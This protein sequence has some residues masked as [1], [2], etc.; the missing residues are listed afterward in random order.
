MNLSSFRR[1]PDTSNCCPQGK[2]DRIGGKDGR[3]AIRWWAAHVDPRRVASFTAS[4]S[5][6]QRGLPRHVPGAPPRRTRPPSRCAV[7]TPARHLASK[8]AVRRTGNALPR[9][10]D[11]YDM[12][13]ACTA[14]RGARAP[15][16]FPVSIDV[17]A[18]RRCAHR[19]GE[20]RLR[21]RHRVNRKARAMRRKPKREQRDRQAQAVTRV[22]IVGKC[23]RNA[24]VFGGTRGNTRFTVSHIEMRNACR[25]EAGR[26]SAHARHCCG[27]SRTAQHI[28][29]TLQKCDLAPGARDADT[30]SC[31]TRQGEYRCVRMHLVSVTHGSDT[32]ADRQVVDGLKKR[33]RR[34]MSAPGTTDTQARSPERAFQHSATTHTRRKHSTAAPSRNPPGPTPGTPPPAQRRAPSPNA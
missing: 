13:G 15:I 30:Q 5:I 19:S 29:E 8:L 6:T 34:A 14:T 20:I 21:Q 11:R 17:V 25:N 1:S 16:R 26:P 9:A 24:S 27:Q 33:E 32:R 22:A 3:M 4:R 23:F 28:E 7:R 12:R 10:H 18:C 31:E 2:A